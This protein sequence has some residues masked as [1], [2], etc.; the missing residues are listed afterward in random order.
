MQKTGIMVIIVCSMVGAGIG[1]SI[2][3]NQ[4]LFEDI[5]TRDGSIDVGSSLTLTKELDPLENPNGVYAVEV[6]DLREGAR[7]TTKIIDPYDR[8][9]ISRQI[10]ADRHEE[11][12]VIVEKG[13]YKLIIE[14]DMGQYHVFA[15]MG[16]AP[17]PGKRSVSFVSV[18]LLIVGLVGMVGVAIYA[19]KNKRR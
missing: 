18:Y 11:N 17:D 16:P 19:I 8:Q 2:Y 4:I 13:E 12:F 7:I 15:A 14:S 9:I 10:T 3:S 1:L 6:I 5:A